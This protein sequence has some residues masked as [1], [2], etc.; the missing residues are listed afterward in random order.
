M[1][2]RNMPQK[3]QDQDRYIV[4]F[5]DG[6]RDRLKSEAS[7]NG[8]SLNAEIIHRLQETLAM[9]DYVPSE[10]AHPD[11]SGGDVLLSVEFMQRLSQTLE[12]VNK[13]LDR[14]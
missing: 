3:T 2:F 8:R 10:N 11:H 5:P 9:D 12:A 7:A 1:A 6:M 13:K 14:K 4:R